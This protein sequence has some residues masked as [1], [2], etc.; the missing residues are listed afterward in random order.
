M[1]FMSRLALPLLAASLLSACSIQPEKPVTPLPGAEIARHCQDWENQRAGEFIVENNIWNKGGTS[2]YRQCVGMAPAKDAKGFDFA[3]DWNWNSPSNEVRAYP[4]LIYGMKP[5]ATQSTSP[6]L[7]RQVSDL[8]VLS[9]RFD[10]ESNRNGKGNLAF[11]LWL[12]STAARAAGETNTPLRHELMIWLEDWGGI[13]PFGS[14]RETVRIDEIDW[15]LYTGTATWGPK[16]WQYIAYRA[17]SPVPAEVSLNLKAFLD[18]LQGRKIIEAQDWLAS[19][20]LGNE[21]MHGQGSTRIR[22]FRLEA[23]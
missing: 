7:P 10:R 9:T 5:W 18:H 2:D 6:V 19:V 1:P 13:V 8:K 16:P 4:E 15:Q 12:T 3:W 11:D 22:N 14:Y 23:E 17:A 21:I 20:E